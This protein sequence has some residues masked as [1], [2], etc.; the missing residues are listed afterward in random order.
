MA[1]WIV[2]PELE[3]LDRSGFKHEAK[4]IIADVENE[5]GEYYRTTCLECGRDAVVKYFLWVKRQ[6]CGGCSR[7]IDLF[8]GYLVASNARHTHF[9]LHCPGCEHL[10]QVPS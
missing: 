9:V 10:I 2:R 6:L 1:V 8:P 5:V 3:T 4:Q 7:P